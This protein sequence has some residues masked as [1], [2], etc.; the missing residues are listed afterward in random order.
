MASD[1]E[2][3]EPAPHPPQIDGAL[4]VAF[5]AVH[6][7][8]EALAVDTFT[9][10]SRFFGRLLASEVITRFQPFFY[11]DGQ[12]AGTGTSGF[13]ILEGNRAR[14]DQLRRDPEFLRVILRAGAATAN[15]RVHTLVAGSEAGRLVNLYREVRG[16][17]GLL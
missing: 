2:I 17:L 4:M 9:E 13:F 6:P 11:A 14:L 15:I 10:V 1:D 7:G 16:D 12:Q 8:R 3:P 5:G